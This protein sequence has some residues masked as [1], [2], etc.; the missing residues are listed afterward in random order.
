MFIR[1]KCTPN[2]AVF[3]C[4]SFSQWERTIGPFGDAQQLLPQ[5]T[6]PLYYVRSVEVFTVESTEGI[7]EIWAREPFPRWGFLRLRVRVRFTYVYGFHPEFIR[8]PVFG[9]ILDSKVRRK[10]T[11][12]DVLFF[13]FVFLSVGEKHWTIW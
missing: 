13:A 9:P 6:A 3:L 10:C 7:S 12:N 1:R 8:N 11:P 4:L 2:D 5:L